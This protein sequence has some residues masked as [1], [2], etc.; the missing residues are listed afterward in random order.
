[1]ITQLQPITALF[2]IPEDNLPAV[3]KKLRAGI[4]LP[5]D[6]YNR[7]NSEML[8]TGQ[9]ETVD[10]Q[11]DST[12][13][14]SKL[15]AVFPNKDNALFPQQFVN[16]RLKVDTL[17]Q[18]LV[19][20][21]V[22]VQNGQQGTFV[23]TVDPETSKVH[24]KTVQVGITD[25]DNAEIKTGLNE[26]DQVVID[27]TDRLDEGTQ[28]RIRKPGELEAIA[29]SGLRA[30]KGGRGKKGGNKG[31]NGQGGQGGAQ[32][33][34]NKSGDPANGQSPAVGDA[35]RGNFGQKSG[36]GQYKGQFNKGQF[37]KKGGGAPQ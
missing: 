13:G 2:T 10:N 23:Y 6:A 8:E 24:L 37:K 1:V 20:P 3:M 22:A 19:V 5:V 15:K 31:A 14:T 34:V 18:K 33:D 32:A 35:A 9:L 27:G 30:G 17:R 12:T 26:G 4:P 25:Q 7:D 29:A 28:V 11:I 36:D 21:F 16:I